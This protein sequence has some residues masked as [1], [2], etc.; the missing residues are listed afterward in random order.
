VRRSLLAVIFTFAAALWLLPFLLAAAASF[1]PS[2]ILDLP[3]ETWSFKWYRTFFNDS[4]WRAALLSSLQVAI[5]SSLIAVGAGAML[6][7]L[8]M[9]RHF[10]GA[11][12]WRILI[13]LPA[14][15]PPAIVGLAMLPIVYFIGDW[16]APWMLA[17][18]HAGFGLPVVYLL[19]QSHLEQTS[20]DLESAARGLGA[21]EWTVWRRITLPLT[22]PALLAG[23][24]ASFVGSMTESV[25][26]IFL[27]TPHNETLPAVIWPQLRYSLSPLTAAAGMI[28]LTTTL[29]GMGIGAMIRQLTTKSKIQPGS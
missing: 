22:M 19:M 11:S 25:A 5:F 7:H 4:R 9:K 28:A 12:I 14:M 2:N 3:T 23:A 16:S 20:P 21:D 6:A 26:C 29:I 24:T 13:V 1:S 10:R 27:A 8:L 17:L 15:I 18:V